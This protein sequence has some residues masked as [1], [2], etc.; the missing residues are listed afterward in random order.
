MGKQEVD[1]GALEELGLHPWS[2]THN[3]A[4]D[5]QGAEGAIEA[6]LYCLSGMNQ[7]VSD[8]RLG[9]ASCQP[10]EHFDS[11]TL[12]SRSK[13]WETARLN[14]YC[15]IR[16][17]WGGLI[18]SFNQQEPVLDRALRK[19]LKDNGLMVTEFSTHLAVR[20]ILP[21]SEEAT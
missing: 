8:W 9:W 16:D 2:V 5:R 18:E 12:N 3:R 13:G 20:G 7:W 21:R 14:G 1:I 11:L 15:S 17:A 6:T 19:R 4:R 10:F